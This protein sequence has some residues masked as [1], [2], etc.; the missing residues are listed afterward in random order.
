MGRICKTPWHKTIQTVKQKEEYVYH[1]DENDKVLGKVSRKEMR[2]KVLLHRGSD[3]FVFNTKG[4]ILV[5]KRTKTKDLFPGFYAV[6]VGG[7]AS[8]GETYDECAKRE[9]YEEIGIKDAQLEFLFKHKYIGPH[10]KFMGH[11]YKMTHDGPFKYQKEEVAWAEFMSL[12]KLKQF[13]KKN[14]FCPDDLEIFNKYLK[15]FHGKK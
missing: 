8:Y 6:V 11:I 5:H 3:I 10:N 9:V 12:S 2:K 1:V 15:E 14:K 4:E 13:M 7:S